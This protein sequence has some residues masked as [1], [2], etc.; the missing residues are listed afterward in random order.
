MVRHT[1]ATILCG[2]LRKEWSIK[3]VFNA[4]ISTR[5]GSKAGA[6]VWTIAS[7]SQDWINRSGGAIHHYERKW[8]PPNVRKLSIYGGTTTILLGHV[9]TAARWKV[10]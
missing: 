1:A 2:G 5:Y 3:I 8:G 4:K 6:S 9:L 7:E 10:T